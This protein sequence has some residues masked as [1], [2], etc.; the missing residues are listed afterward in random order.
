M[1]T[2]TRLDEWTERLPEHVDEV[3]ALAQGC[4]RCDL[5]KDATQ[6]VFG[7]G[8]ADARIVVVGEQP[9]DV[10]DLEGTPFVGPSGRL[11]DEAFEEAGIAR[12][13]VYVTNAVKHFKHE[14]RG[15]RRIH[16]TPRAN[17]VR[18]CRPW[19][20]A[21]LTLLDPEL[22]LVLG[23][24]AAKA[25]LGSSFRVTRQRGEVVEA[26]GLRVIATVHPS[27]VLRTPSA[28]RA[29]ARAEFLDDIGVAGRLLGG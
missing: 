25:L 13:A 11:L 3:R 28:R 22:V 5:Y 4:T 19:L 2:S 1:A 6:T 24:T 10:E 21:E 29:Q 17:E 23:A 26:A 7:E 14:R 20:D 12:D 15:K 16:Q 8:P 9:G 18:A 27:A